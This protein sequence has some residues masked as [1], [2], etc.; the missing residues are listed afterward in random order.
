VPWKIQTRDKNQIV[1]SK[2]PITPSLAVRLTI[3]IRFRRALAL[4]ETSFAFMVQSYT[5]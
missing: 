5:P 1:K 2:K 3:L 4:G